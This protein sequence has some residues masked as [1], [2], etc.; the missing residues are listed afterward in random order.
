MKI[1]KNIKTELGK[2]LFTKSRKKLGGGL[3]CLSFLF[4]SL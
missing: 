2:D 1:L 3:C 4:L